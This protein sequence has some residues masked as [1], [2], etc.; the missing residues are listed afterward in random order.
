M[1]RCAAVTRWRPASLLAIFKLPAAPPG[2]GRRSSSATREVCYRRNTFMGGDGVGCSRR[3]RLLSGAPDRSWVAVAT[4]RARAR[5]TGVRHGHRWTSFFFISYCICAR[6]SSSGLLRARTRRA[7]YFFLVK[8]LKLYR[9][10]VARAC[11]CDC[12][13]VYGER[14]ASVASARSAY[15]GNMEIRGGGIIIADQVTGQLSSDRPRGSVQS[16]PLDWTSGD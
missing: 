8:Q 2:D 4:A 3:A 10:R 13:P 5:A 9:S 15:V 12:G 14:A 7:Y 11:G 1:A 16:G 6:S